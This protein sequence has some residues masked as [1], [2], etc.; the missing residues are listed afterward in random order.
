MYNSADT[1]TVYLHIFRPISTIDELKTKIREF[2]PL[3]A[4]TGSASGDTG[5]SNNDSGSGSQ[6]QV[7]HPASQTNFTAAEAMLQRLRRK[8]NIMRNDPVRVESQNF[9]EAEFIYYIHT[10]S[11]S[12][13]LVKI[14]DHLLKIQPN[15]CEVERA[16]S[17][18]SLFTTKIRSRLGD[19]TLNMLCSLRHWMFALI[20]D[21][22]DKAAVSV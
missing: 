18:A 22:K 2:I 12:A 11:M 16:F 1:T 21:G 8:M 15:S 20:K 10:G 7:P 4:I 3:L 5:P 9:V 13:S 6:P 19:S 17:A 14:R